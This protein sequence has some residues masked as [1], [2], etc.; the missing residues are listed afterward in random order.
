MSTKFPF[1]FRSCRSL[2]GLMIYSA[3]D[4]SPLTGRDPSV[5]TSSITIEQI[6][7]LDESTPAARAVGNFLQVQRIVHN[8]AG[9]IVSTNPFLA[10]RQRLGVLD[11]KPSA[12]A[13]TKSSIGCFLHWDCAWTVN[14][15]PR[16]STAIAV[17]SVC[18]VIMCAAS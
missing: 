18:F 16:K 1:T 9:E 8:P 15:K 12:T 6:Y 2:I 4:I 14:D 7:C 5:E 11:P 13:L 10:A 3:I 17:T